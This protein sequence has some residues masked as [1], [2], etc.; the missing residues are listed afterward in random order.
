VAA[1]LKIKL[2]SSCA[3][4]VFQGMVQYAATIAPAD[5]ILNINHALHIL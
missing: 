3:H 5:S 1:F 4:N 2:R